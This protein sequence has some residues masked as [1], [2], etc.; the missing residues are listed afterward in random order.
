MFFKYIFLSSLILFGLSSCSPSS[1]GSTIESSDTTPPTFTSSQTVSVNENQIDVITL[2][3]TDESTV[4]YSISGS[5]S[6]SF[7]IN[8]TSGVV[9]F[10]VA[11]DYEA[12][13]IKRI[14][15]FI[16]KARDSAGN[17][18]IQNITITLNDVNESQLHPLL[19]TGQTQSITDYDDGYYK[20]GVARNY[21]R[22][23][24]VVQDHV[25]WLQW[26]D[27]TTPDEMT[28]EEAKAYCTDLTL[29]GETDWRLPTRKELV[30]LSYYGRTSPAIDR[31]FQNTFSSRYWSSTT[32][33]GR[34][35]SAWIVGFKH[36]NQGNDTKNYNYAVR[37]VR[38][39][40]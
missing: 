39:G 18:E 25:A 30:S 33:A 40:Q 13:P 28:W 38:A 23:S 35:N 7:N 19:K 2:V 12:T 21:T 3:A 22:G 31:V 34:T 14:F 17:E 16:A 4:T 10:K 11:P 8:P 37:C 5:D 9:T 27:N 36:G 24:D 26:Q 15:T 6:T 20:K 32:L 1:D 29:G